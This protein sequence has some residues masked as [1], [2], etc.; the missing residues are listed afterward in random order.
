MNYT[1]Y[2]RVCEHFFSPKISQAGAVKGLKVKKN[3]QCVS[4]LHSFIKQD[5]DIYM[6]EKNSICFDKTQRKH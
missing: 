1:V 5:P 4:K 6:V 3:F 2:K